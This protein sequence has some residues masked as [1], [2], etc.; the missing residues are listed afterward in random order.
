MPEDIPDTP[1]ARRAATRWEIENTQSATDADKTDVLKTPNR[2]NRRPFGH[3]KYRT[4]E[5]RNRQNI[6][7]GAQT[8]AADARIVIKVAIFKP[9]IT[10]LN[11]AR[12]FSF[13]LLFRFIM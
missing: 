4:K 5:V 1:R 2:Q 13:F 12:R 7:P 8:Y 6:L 3:V 11:Q 10:L 9:Y